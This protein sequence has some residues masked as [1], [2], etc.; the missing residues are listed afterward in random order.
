[1]SQE[2][3]TGPALTRCTHLPLGRWKLKYSGGLTGYEQT[4]HIL[5]V[6]LP[7]YK[8]RYIGGL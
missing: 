5:I 6:L 7:E 8:V 4:L 3:T 2:E 1:V